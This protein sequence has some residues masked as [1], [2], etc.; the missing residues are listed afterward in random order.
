[1]RAE[2]KG[3]GHQAKTPARPAGY[4]AQS[5]QGARSIKPKGAE[6]RPAI[7]PRDERLALERAAELRPDR[8]PW[9]PR[10]VSAATI[11]VPSGQADCRW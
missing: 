11:A 4:A 7:P 6:P 8:E 3:H 5:P 1:M 9:A 2:P 10:L